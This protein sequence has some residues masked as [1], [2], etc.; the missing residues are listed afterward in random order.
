MQLP[1][2]TNK[3]FYNYV[4]IIV[5]TKVIV[6]QSLLVNFT[7]FEA[8]MCHL[9]MC[10]CVWLR[11]SVQTFT[12]YYFVN[13]T[14]PVLAF[15]EKCIIYPFKCHSFVKMTFAAE[16]HTRCIPIPRCNAAFDSQMHCKMLK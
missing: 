5:G 14:Q 10:V 12:K 16:L 3:Y 9:V 13:I 1:K 6:P 15:N 4:T 11:E 2:D 8:K 7:R